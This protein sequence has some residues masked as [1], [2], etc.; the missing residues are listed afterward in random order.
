MRPSL[1]YRTYGT[2]GTK[3][4]EGQRYSVWQYAVFDVSTGEELWHHREY[5]DGWFDF[6]IA[7]R[8]AYEA[9]FVADDGQLLITIDPKIGPRAPWMDVRIYRPDEVVSI[10]FAA[11]C[12]FP[13]RLYP[14]ESRPWPYRHGL[15][16]WSGAGARKWWSDATYDGRVLSINT[17]GT[18]SCRID[19]PALVERLSQGETVEEALAQVAQRSL[20]IATLIRWLVY[21]VVVVPA[22]FVVLRSAARVP[23]WLLARYRR[24]RASG[25]RCP[26]CGY[27]VYGL[28]DP[29]CPE[30]GKM[31]DADLLVAAEP[32]SATANPCFW[33]FV[34]AL[35]CG[36]AVHV[37]V[38]ELRVLVY[39]YVPTIGTVGLESSGG[40]TVGA[41]YLPW[42]CSEFVL[43]WPPIIIAIITYRLLR[44]R[45]G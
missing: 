40:V 26:Q 14:G 11:I 21:A 45:R 33:P 15:H 23:G 22:A 13:R 34:V 31:F 36:L 7:T 29:R 3:R 12:R 37:G 24:S 4:D 28:T 10:P 16:V 25:H 20:N 6:D 1:S 8:F 5:Q 32:P 43:A 41:F 30:C 19:V 9:A 39:R 18:L 2:E 38:H 42:W 44:S 35:A 17:T 27:P